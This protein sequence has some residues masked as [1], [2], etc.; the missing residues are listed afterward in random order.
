MKH[1]I[2]RGV[3]KNMLAIGLPLVLAVCVFSG[4]VSAPKLAGGRAAPGS[5]TVTG[6]PAEYNGKFAHFAWRRD[7]TSAGFVP[8]STGGKGIAIT[9]NEVKLPFTLGKGGKDGG[10]TG[11]DTLAVVLIFADTSEPLPVAL[12][13]SNISV[14]ES[15]DAIYS[16]VRFANGA[17]VVN[18]ADAFKAAY[19]TITNFPENFGAPIYGLDSNSGSISVTY[20]TIPGSGHR[21]RIMNGSLTLKYHHWRAGTKGYIPYVENTLVIEVSSDKDSKA[22]TGSGLSSLVT[23]SA[24]R[25]PYVF[26]VPAASGETTIVDFSDGVKQE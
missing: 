16:T 22:P 25:V 12:I 24:D 6:L 7:G 26:T 21:E 18:W 11:S 23:I 15:A 2:N 5:L 10:Y 9:N 14:F 13:G 3:I 19:I 8:G 1:L 20:R 17:A 4:C